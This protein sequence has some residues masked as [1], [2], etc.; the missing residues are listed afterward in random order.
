MDVYVWR[1]D[2]E[3][4]FAHIVTLWHNGTPFQHKHILAN[5]LKLVCVYCI[6]SGKLNG[7]FY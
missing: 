4:C 7:V 3:L 5:S 1:T 2:Y 6:Y